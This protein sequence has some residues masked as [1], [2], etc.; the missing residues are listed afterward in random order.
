MSTH[1][2]DAL[3]LTSDWLCVCARVGAV[4]VRCVC[5]L[6]GLNRC[7]RVCTCMFLCVLGGTCDLFGYACM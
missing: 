7:V 3:P 6:S 4:G 1:F 2:P 5:L